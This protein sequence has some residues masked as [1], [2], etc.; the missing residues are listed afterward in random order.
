MPKLKKLSIQEFSK[1][2]EIYAGNI[3]DQTSQCAITPNCI[4]KGRPVT[5]A[6]ELVAH[7]HTIRATILHQKSFQESDSKP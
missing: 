1:L 7:L 6:G 2:P 4:Q 3:H 5:R